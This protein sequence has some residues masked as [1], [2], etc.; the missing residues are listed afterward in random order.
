MYA[1]YGQTAQWRNSD[2]YRSASQDAYNLISIDTINT[3]IKIVRGGGADIDNH[4]RTR[5]GIAFNY[6]TGEIVGQVL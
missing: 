6:S 2:Q 3:L 1:G 5:K 4:M